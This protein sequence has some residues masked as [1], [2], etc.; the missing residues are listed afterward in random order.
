[1]KVLAAGK[2][3]DPRRRATVLLAAMG[4]AAV[5]LAA[6][7]FAA[8]GLGL[9]TLAALPALA[10]EEMSK[11]IDVRIEG[12]RV[13][14]PQGPIRVKRGDIVELRWQTDEA[15]RL[16]LHGYDVELTVKPGRAAKM[17]IR[18]RVAG[19]FPIT[20]HGWGVRGHGQGNGHDALT[21]LEVLPR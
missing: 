4:L 17:V 12:R 1:M 21:Y 16:H 10:A 2:A 8:M 14:A 19:R 20:S 18:A 7:G 5:G 9:S 11:V 15:V 6:V 3:A 13:A